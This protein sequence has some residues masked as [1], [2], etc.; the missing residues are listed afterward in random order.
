MR[1]A[2]WIIGRTSEAL[3][4]HDQCRRQPRRDRGILSRTAPSGDT[5]G[6]EL[7]AKPRRSRWIIEG[8]ES[9]QDHGSLCL[10]LS[11]S[12]SLARRSRSLFSQ[13]RQDQTKALGVYGRF[14]LRLPGTA[15]TAP[16][17]DKSTGRMRHQGCW[18]GRDYL[19]AE[20]GSVSAGS[21]RSVA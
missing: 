5:F 20:S 4:A 9:R 2:A 21:R 7:D 11:L 8:L 14:L 16:Y 10:V 17:L 15:M 18:T 3:F 6:T 1:S 19:Q 12:V 13:Y